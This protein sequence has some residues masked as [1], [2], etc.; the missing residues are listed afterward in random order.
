MRT[1]IGSFIRLLRRACLFLKPGL[2]SELVEILSS[3]RKSLLRILL[4]GHGKVEL[5]SEAFDEVDSVGKGREFLR[6]RDQGFELAHFRTL[7]D[8]LGIIED[9]SLGGSPAGERPLLHCF[10]GLDP[11]DEGPGGFL[12]RARVRNCP[13]P[14]AIETAARVRRNARLAD[15]LRG[16]RVV[17]PSEQDVEGH[18]AVSLPLSEYVRS[19]VETEALRTGRSMLRDVLL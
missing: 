12:V 18:E 13:A 3:D 1:S 6:G 15:H 10:L 14:A 16:L 9:P 19:F 17:E 4:A 2:G 5:A 7:G 11:F 8:D